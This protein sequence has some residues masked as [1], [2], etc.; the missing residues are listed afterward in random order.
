MLNHFSSTALSLTLQILSIVNILK[1]LA[2]SG[3]VLLLKVHGILALYG[4]GLLCKSVKGSTNISLVMEDFISPLDI[5]L[6]FSKK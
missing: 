2:W 5:G 6:R 1:S 4:P 3:P